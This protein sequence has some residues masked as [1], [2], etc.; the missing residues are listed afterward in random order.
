MRSLAGAVVLVAWAI[1][2]GAAAVGAEPAPGSAA[3]FEQLK[4]RV[5]QLEQETE[6]L[7]KELAALKEELAAARREAGGPAARPAAPAG[8]GPVRSL[9]RSRQTAN[10]SNAAA[11]LK[12]LVTMNAIWRS[13]DIDRNGVGDYWT[14]DIAAFYTAHD[15]AGN[16]VKL[17]DKRFAQADAAPARAYPELDKEPAP[18]QGYLFRAL[19]ADQEGKCLADPA[20]TPPTAGNLAPGPS[21]HA[22]RFAFCAYPVRHGEDGVLTFIVSEDGVVWQKDLGPDAKGVDTWPGDPQDSGWTQFGG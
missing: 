1:S 8:P 21:T 4:A 6:L 14:R 19:K 2:A 12:A 3:E 5:K 9:I 13:Q 7:H 22:S 16:A 17:I 18:K 11:A 20:S 10:H 15:A